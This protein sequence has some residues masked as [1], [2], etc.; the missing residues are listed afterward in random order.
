MDD[1]QTVRVRGEGCSGTNGGPN[2]DVLVE[3]SIREHPIFHREDLT[4]YVEIPITFTQAALGAEL[5]VPTLEG[6]VPYTIPEGTQTGTM[7][8][9]P[10]K[11]IPM[12]GNSRRRGDLRFRVVVETPTKLNREQK[13]LLSKLA[14][15]LDGNSKKS[16]SFGEKVKEFFD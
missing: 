2:G 4:V 6:K 15:S 14:E 9:L 11:G 13:E 1:G 5:Q 10:G 16:K 8:T 3:I 12:I 7:F